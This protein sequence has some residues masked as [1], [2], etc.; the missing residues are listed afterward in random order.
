MIPLPDCHQSDSADCYPEFQ[1]SRKQCVG[2]LKSEN[3]ERTILQECTVSTNCHVSEGPTPSKYA[4]P[5]TSLGVRKCPFKCQS[6]ETSP[7]WRKLQLFHSG[8]HQAHPTLRKKQAGQVRWDLSGKRLR[9]C[10]FFFLW[11]FLITAPPRR[12]VLMRNHMNAYH[13]ASLLH[14]LDEKFRL[15]VGVRIA[16][17]CL[18][19]HFVLLSE[20]G[21]RLGS[22][23]GGESSKKLSGTNSSDNS[24][25]LNCIIFASFFWCKTGREVGGRFFFFV[26]GQFL[27]SA[28]TTICI[29]APAAEQ[30]PQHS[31][32][33]NHDYLL[34]PWQDTGLVPW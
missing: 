29:I 4:S 18:L 28:A 6:L 16:S 9:R 26:C 5:A 3:I 32:M 19:H 31:K 1:Q 11:W 20:P 17:F 13:F 15:F 33:N 7:M 30:P 12:G 25:C 2:D 21:G 23:R 8:C 24:C 14:H 10:M 22:G 34:V 27:P